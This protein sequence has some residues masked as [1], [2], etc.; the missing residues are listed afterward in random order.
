MLHHHK[1]CHAQLPTVPPHRNQIPLYH[2]V[3]HHLATMPDHRRPR[4]AHLLPVPLHHILVPRHLVPML[5]IADC[6]VRTYSRYPF[7]ASWCPVTSPRCSIIADWAMRT[8]SW[9]P[10]TMSRCIVTS[11]CD[12]PS[13]SR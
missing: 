8:Y 7:T 11:Y 4:R 10:F 9:R 6:A 2:P 13:K 1:L 3:P 5:I 12:L